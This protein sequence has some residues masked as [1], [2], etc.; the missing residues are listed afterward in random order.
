[1]GRLK[2]TA[3]ETMPSPVGRRVA[4]KVNEEDRKKLEKLDQAA[5]N[6]KDGIKKE[7]KKVRIIQ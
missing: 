5:R 1:M 7:K 6:A 4:P 2:I 3:A